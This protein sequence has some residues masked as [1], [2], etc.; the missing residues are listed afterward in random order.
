V[1]A[2]IGTPISWLR[3]ET[4]ALADRG[5]PAITDHLASCPACRSCLDEIR[6]DVVALPPLAIA[7]PPTPW[8]RRLRWIAPAMAAAAAIVLFVVIR[9][10][11]P[12]QRRDDVATIK[13]AGDVVLGV[14]RERAGTIRTDVRTF[15]PGDRWK[16]VI[17]C[18]ANTSVWVD[19]AVIDS[20]GADYPLGVVQVPCGNQIA[21]PGAFSI[22]GS[23]VNRVCARIATG[24]APPRAIDVRDPAAARD[25]ACVT[26]RPE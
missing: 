7:A 15:S 4:Y 20:H 3:L 21:V 22:T 10:P 9:R 14:V 16:A 2:C 8:W 18:A 11:G 12:E 5:D 17:T 25:V 26:L 13:G 1:T 19:V 24:V 23:E 6:G